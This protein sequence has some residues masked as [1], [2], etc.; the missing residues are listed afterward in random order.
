M[1]MKHTTSQIMPLVVLTS[2]WLLLRFTV[3]GG[4]EGGLPELLLAREDVLDDPMLPSLGMAAKDGP[5]ST[6]MGCMPFF[7]LSIE[8][9][10]GGW[11]G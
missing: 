4:L 5:V 3:P 8:L 1:P 2:I 11:V 7:P 9:W 10:E 6:S